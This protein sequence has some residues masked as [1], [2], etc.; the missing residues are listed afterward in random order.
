[1]DAIMLLQQDINLDKNKK[2]IGNNERVIIDK[3]LDEYSSVGRTY[4][5]SPEVDNTVII[6]GHHPVGEFLD[7]K[8]TDA[9][10]YELEASP[11]K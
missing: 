5:D 2:L 3:H 10:E 7:V 1:M 9:S 4:R 11:L 8:I 6:D